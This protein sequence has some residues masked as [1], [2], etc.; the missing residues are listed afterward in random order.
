MTVNDLRIAIID[1]IEAKWEYK[2]LATKLLNQLDQ[3]GITEE[4]KV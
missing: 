1:I 2:K 4:E 3:E